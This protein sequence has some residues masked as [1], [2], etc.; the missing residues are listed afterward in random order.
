MAN[1]KKIMIVDDDPDILYSLKQI[2]E[3]EGYIV[4]TFEDGNECIRELENGTKPSLIILDVMMPIMSGW[5]VHRRLGQNR[6]WMKIPVVFLT[7]RCND[8]AEEMYERYG[9]TRIKK[10]FNIQEFKNK[11]EEILF[12]RQKFTKVMAECHLQVLS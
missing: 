3:S 1:K 11:I 5:E 10:P 6:K 7:A 12:H 4:Y 2:L 8:T 9:I